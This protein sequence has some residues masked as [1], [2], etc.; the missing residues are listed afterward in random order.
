MFRAIILL[1][2]LCQLTLAIEF[3]FWNKLPGDVWVGC[4]GNP[5]KPHL[6]GGGWILKPWQRVIYC[7][8]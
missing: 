1:L 7:N 6:N 8:F 3:Q 5:G 2:A 4:Q